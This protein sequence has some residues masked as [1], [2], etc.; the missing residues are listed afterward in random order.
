MDRVQAQMNNAMAASNL[1]G[2]RA[3][4]QDA[5]ANAGIHFSVRQ[6]ARNAIHLRTI[7]ITPN[8]DGSLNLNTADSLNT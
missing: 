3:Q 4:T 8:R 7:T 5:M 2:A 1:L 6:D